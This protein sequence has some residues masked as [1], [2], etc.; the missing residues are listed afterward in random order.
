M[1]PIFGFLVFPM[2]W[3]LP[4][5]SAS[6]SLGGVLSFTHLE[7][8]FFILSKLPCRIVCLLDEHFWLGFIAADLCTWRLVDN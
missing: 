5:H 4:S 2:K 1:L 3:Q 7:M 6:H 8:S